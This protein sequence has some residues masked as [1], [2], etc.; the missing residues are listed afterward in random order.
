MP[1]QVDQDRYVISFDCE[2]TG[3]SV[4]KDQIV[5]LG[6]TVYRW[7]ASACT[8]KSCGSFA[9]YARPTVAR[10]SKKA[11][12][13]TGITAEQLAP[14]DT[15]GT[16]LAA[17]KDFV[18]QACPD[19]DVPRVLV[20]YNGFAYDLPIMVAELERIASGRSLAYFREL[21]V[22]W[23]LDMLPLCRQRLDSSRMVRK[24]NGACS[25][26][27]GDV[28][29]SVCQKALQGAHGALADSEAVMRI[30]QCSE[31]RACLRSELAPE[32][33][34]E[35]DRGTMEN[36]MTL[37]RGI[38]DKIDRMSRKREAQGVCDMITTFKRRRTSAV[39]ISQTAHEENKR[40]KK[41][42]AR[43]KE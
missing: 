31:L 8:F 7:T 3:L 17:F 21:H 4:Y 6:A 18:E 34:T 41:R 29:M 16:V 24:A 15:I 10:M 27:L 5:E 23:A 40:E 19:R 30:M 9:Q 14:H 42:V 32:E 25:Y 28:Y 33:D 11:S 39:E 2:S 1:E 43:R 12:Q 37:V 13:I 26:R 22:E 35:Q 36:T 38:R 20:S